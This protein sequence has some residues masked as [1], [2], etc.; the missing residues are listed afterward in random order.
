MARWASPGREAGSRWMCHRLCAETLDKSLP[1]V[2]PPPLQHRTTSMPSSVL[3]MQYNRVD[4][5]LSSRV[6]RMVSSQ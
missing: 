5:L 6:W 2:R 3:W 4:K 1:E